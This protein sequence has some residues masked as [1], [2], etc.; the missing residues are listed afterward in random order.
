MHRAH[1]ELAVKYFDRIKKDVNE[2]VDKRYRPFVIDF[3]IRDLKLLDAIEEARKP[4]AKLDPLEVMEIYVTQVLK[5]I[6]NKREEYLAPILENEKKVLKAIDESYENIQNANAIVTGHL[7]S[8]IKVHDAQAELLEKIDMGDLR[9]KFIENT[10][11]LSDTIAEAVDEAREI[12][13]KLKGAESQI[14]KIKDVAE[15]LEKIIKGFKIE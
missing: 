9:T 3:T 14:H 7:A 2:F 1:R 15:K 10:V 4:G 5:N 12:D 8:I 6:E 13:V 11:K